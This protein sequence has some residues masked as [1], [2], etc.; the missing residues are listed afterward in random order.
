MRSM[1][2]TDVGLELLA[3]FIRNMP[4]CL[5][6]MQR[7]KDP[8]TLPKKVYMITE[9][10]GRGRGNTDINLRESAKFYTVPIS[11][12]EKQLVTDQDEG[13]ANNRVIAIR[14]KDGDTMIPNAPLFCQDVLDKS[15]GHA[16]KPW[17]EAIKDLD[18]DAIKGEV[19]QTAEQFKKQGKAEKQAIAAGIILVADRLAE[20]YIFHDGVRLTAEDLR[21]ILKDDTEV[22][23]RQ[24]AYDA[25]CSLISENGNNFINGSFT[26]NGRVWGKIMDANGDHIAFNADVFNEEMR[27]RNFDPSMFADWAIEHGIF[28]DGRVNRDGSKRG[29]GKHKTV[30]TR[31][32]PGKPPVWCWMINMTI[33]PSIHPDNTDNN[34]PGSTPFGFTKVDN[35]WPGDQAKNPTEN[36]TENA[37]EMYAQESLNV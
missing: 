9:G 4:L 31:I 33:D 11:T 36:Q 28:E 10:S 29:D 18:Y 21:P 34:P 7:I 1:D 3:G 15:W 8:K 5:N 17:I 19:L 25:M 23:D 14:V 6:E 30:K 24:R 13:G 20:Q 27:K 12:G 2:N 37:T 22:D 35:E 26:P 16:A 32:E